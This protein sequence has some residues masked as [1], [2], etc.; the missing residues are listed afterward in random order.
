M[1]CCSLIRVDYAH[2]PARAKQICCHFADDNFKCIFFNENVGISFKISLKFVPKVWINDIPAMVQI[3]AWRQ[4]GDINSLAPG[5][6]GG[7]V[8]SII[9]KPITRKSSLGTRC[10]IALRWMSLKYTNEKSTE[11]QVM[12]WCHQTTSHY[13]RKCWC[14]S[15]LPYDVTIPG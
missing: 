13:L 11:D 14:R 1:F 12:T 8:Q 3:M 6:Y 7:N 9:F 15:M 5:R 2:I 4:P 10:K